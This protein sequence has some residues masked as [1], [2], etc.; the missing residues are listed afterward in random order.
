MLCLRDSRVM[1][2]AMVYGLTFVVVCC[3]CVLLLMCLCGVC[4][5]LCVVVWFVACA[6]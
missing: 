3:L 1:Y 6:D 2:G 5:L 4:G